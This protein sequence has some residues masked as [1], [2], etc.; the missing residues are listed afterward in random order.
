M[1]PLILQKVSKSVFKITGMNMYKLPIRRP[2]CRD[3][4]AQVTSWQ[5]QRP[6][7]QTRLITRWLIPFPHSPLLVLW[8]SHT[9]QRTTSIHTNAPNSAELQLTFGVSNVL[10]YSQ[11]WLHLYGM[12]VERLTIKYFSF[13]TLTTVECLPLSNLVLTSCIVSF[14]VLKF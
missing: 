1:C 3:F 2:P 14:K 9:P 10:S 5:H 12:T 8:T 7:T 4:V 11:Q 13:I 6:P